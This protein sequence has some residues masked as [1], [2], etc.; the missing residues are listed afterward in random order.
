[1]N[2]CFF[3]ELNECESSPCENEGSCEDQV[4]GYLCICA[5]GFTGSEC[6]TGSVNVVTAG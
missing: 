2:M 6:E 5:S 3:L 1:M 4:D